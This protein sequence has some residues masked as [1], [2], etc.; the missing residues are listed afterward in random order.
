MR[1]AARLPIN[2]C[3]CAVA[4]S[5]APAV[6]GAPSLRDGPLRGSSTRILSLGWHICTG[7]R[8][9]WAKPCWPRGFSKWTLWQFSQGLCGRTAAMGRT[10]N[11]RSAFA[12]FAILLSFEL[13]G[14][15]AH[16]P[17]KPREN[18]HSVGSVMPR[19]SWC[20]A[21]LSVAII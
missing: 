7:L 10:S 14:Y 13:Y 9:T 6:C 19:A 20:A 3:W 11:G 18:C 4:R 1:C 16:P 12:Q 8:V 5:A 21:I 2:A 17:H 15:R